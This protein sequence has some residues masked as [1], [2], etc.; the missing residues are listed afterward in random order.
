MGGPANRISL[1]QGWHANHASH[2]AMPFLPTFHARNTWP[3]AL[4]TGSLLLL[5]LFLAFWLRQTYADELDVLKKESNVLFINTVR[6]MEGELME[7]LMRREQ[8]GAWPDSMEALIGQ[9]KRT[10]VKVFPKDTNRT[11]VRFQEH[12]N[13]TVLRD[14]QVNVFLRTAG[15]PESPQ[16]RG[17]LSLMIRL[18][19]NAPQAN[20]LF[21]R[22]AA[23]SNLP[24]LVTRKFE[25]SLRESG[26]PVQYRIVPTRDSLPHQRVF[27]SDTYVDLATG[28]RLTAEFSG[29]QGYIWTRILPEAG[30]A[31]LLFASVGLAFFTMYRSWQKQRRLTELKNDFINN[32]THELKT[33][34]AT[35]SVAIEALSSFDALRDPRRTGEY[36]NIAR[37][38]LG[39]LSLL[40]DKVLKMSLFE[41]DRPQL[42]PEPLNF[43]ALVEEVLASMQLQFEK[44][45]ARV[46]FEARDGDFHLTGDRLH[47]TSVIYNLLDNALKYSAADPE[48][49]I[50]LA[51]QDGTLRMTV[52]DRG[53]GI[54]AEYQHRIFD[55]FFRVPTGDV[56]NTRGHGLGLH[57]VANVVRQHLGTIRAEAGPGGEGTCFTVTLPLSV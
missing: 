21:L 11:V 29:F 36:L 56:H 17:S 35:V 24:V 57:Y 45:G 25:E 1:L 6:S 44:S 55:K 18:N 54:P 9:P 4:M 52:R 42:H 39:R 47:L 7:N 2:P 51:R 16:F 31:L 30:F 32:V 49:Q 19:K 27:Q 34:I 41:Q 13:G 28:E 53:I 5:G 33:P 14:S 12:R 3:L 22:M 8:G 38:E 26:L 23:D 43:R 40:V 37:L 20:S 50:G 15:D 46:R 48:I 10:L